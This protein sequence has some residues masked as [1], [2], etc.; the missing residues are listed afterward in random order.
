M[1]LSGGEM[2]LEAS[3]TADSV[4]RHSM[5]S[6]LSAGFEAY[7]TEGRKRTGVMTCLLLFP[8]RTCHSQGSKQE[9]KT[10]K[11]AQ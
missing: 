8:A 11:E 9:E 7:I 3:L 4:E 2:S 1:L 5:T 10:P 6:G